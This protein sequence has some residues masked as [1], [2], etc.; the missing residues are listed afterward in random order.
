MCRWLRCL[1]ALEDPR[2]QAKAR[3]DDSVVFLEKL[4]PGNPRQIANVLDRLVSVS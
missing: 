1:Y 2:G 4:S 3:P